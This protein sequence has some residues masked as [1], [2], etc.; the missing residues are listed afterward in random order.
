M[1]TNHES[2]N[3]L[4]I[5]VSFHNM[6]LLIEYMYTGECE[7]ESIQLS[8]F[9]QD[10]EYLHV[11]GL[12]H[13]NTSAEN[14]G[15]IILRNHELKS[16]SVN[17]FRSCY[18]DTTLSDINIMCKG[19]ELVKAHKLVLASSSAV[20]EEIIIR[21]SSHVIKL[22]ISLQ[23]L[24]ILL[25]LLYTGECK[26]KHQSLHLAQKDIKDLQIEGIYIDYKKLD[27]ELNLQPKNLS[28]SHVEK[29]KSIIIES[30][31]IDPSDY[32]KKNK[33]EIEENKLDIQ[34]K[35][36]PL[37]KGENFVHRT[38]SNFTCPHCE[39]VFSYILKLERHMNAFKGQG[40]RRV[41]NPEI[42]CTVCGFLT[43]KST[44]TASQGSIRNHMITFHWEKN[45]ICESVGCDFRT[46]TKS[47]LND[48]KQRIHN[49]ENIISCE[50]CGFLTHCKK[51]LVAHTKYKHDDS[52]HK[53]DSCE[54]QFRTYVACKNHMNW[55]HLGIKYECDSCEKQFRTHVARKNHVNSAHLGIT[56]TCHV[57]GYVAQRKDVLKEH[58]QGEH[59]GKTFDCNTQGCELKFKRRCYLNRHKSQHQS[60]QLN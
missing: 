14:N 17:V 45:I 33:K 32:V 40:C 39:K 18:K 59:E 11:N 20:L 52:M 29:G 5:D 55:A 58:V 42:S 16:F 23:N 10:V 46:N 34:P 43:L 50:L 8:G 3:E 27:S 12:N 26:V 25:E 13:N 21:G 53:C 15:K 22:D 35:H 51:Y 48:H 7:V 31:L 2:V 9:L 6:D 44:R 56:Y 60:T 38:K 19:N 47:A 54:E 36:N 30:Y 24:E 41:E 37:K 49:K 28:S 1:F 57:C 4:K